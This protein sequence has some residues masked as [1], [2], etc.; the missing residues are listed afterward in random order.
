MRDRGSG[1]WTPKVVV[2][3]LCRIREGSGRNRKAAD[4]DS[5]ARF[6]VRPLTEPTERRHSYICEYSLRWL[7][8]VRKVL[9]GYQVFF[10]SFLPIRCVICA[11]GL[12]CC[13]Q[14]LPMMRANPPLCTVVSPTST[15][16]RFP[17]LCMAAAPPAVRRRL[18]GMPCI[19]WFA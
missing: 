6:T 7:P 10:A 1:E 5:A 12:R 17:D 13:M 8:S 11:C 15:T 18:S 2:G 9:G 3:V 19:L 4:R 16:L 14:D